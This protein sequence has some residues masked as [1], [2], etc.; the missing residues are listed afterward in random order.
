MFDGS[1]TAPAISVL[2]LLFLPENFTAHSRIQISDE[3]TTI[4]STAHA[5]PIKVSPK[6][7]SDAFTQKDFGGPTPK[8]APFPYV[9]L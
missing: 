7:C 9:I 5:V 8:H 2:Q 6:I 1:L 4:L 3:P